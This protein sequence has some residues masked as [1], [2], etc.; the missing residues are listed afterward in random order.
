MFDQV[1]GNYYI[2][3][4]VM[5]VLL[6]ADI[7]NFNTG[8]AIAYKECCQVWLKIGTSRF[9]YILR[10]QDHSFIKLNQ[11]LLNK[12][13]ACMTSQEVLQAQNTYIEEEQKPR[14]KSKDYSEFYPR[15]SSE[16]TSD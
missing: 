9:H 15:S 2:E 10:M 13:T 6:T 16:K 4:M 3:W 8:I 1:E 7:S 14:S 5:I 12:Y 11:T